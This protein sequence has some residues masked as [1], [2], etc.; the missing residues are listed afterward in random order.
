MLPDELLARLERW[1]K[2]NDCVTDPTSTVQ[3]CRHYLPQLIEEVR[4]LQA[5]V[6]G[7]DL[8]AL[9]EES[10][11]DTLANGVEVP[12]GEAASVVGGDGNTGLPGDGDRQAEVRPA[13]AKRKWKRRSPETEPSPPTGPDS[14]GNLGQADEGDSVQMDGEPRL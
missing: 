6:V 9:M 4:T 8:F 13:R 7:R 2:S 10:K 1:A 3:V 5:M 12:S 11:G 14:R